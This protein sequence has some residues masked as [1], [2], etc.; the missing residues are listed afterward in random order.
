MTKPTLILICLFCCKSYLSNAQI[1]S[2]LFSGTIEYE[3]TINMHA[4]VKQMIGPNATVNQ[5]KAFENYVR[6][7]PKFDI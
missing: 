6:T 3:K 5:Q 1:A 4:R 2:F 7:Q